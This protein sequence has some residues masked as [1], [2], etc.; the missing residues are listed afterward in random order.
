MLRHQRGHRFAERR[1][2]VARLGH[3]QQRHG[4]GAQHARVA[5][6]ALLRP[7]RGQ[8]LQDG[9]RRDRGAHYGFLHTWP[10]RASISSAAA[11]P[12]LPAA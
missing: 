4:A 2:I 5:L 1:G 10:R 7:E 11:G 6:L 8:F 3:H 12:Q 9:V